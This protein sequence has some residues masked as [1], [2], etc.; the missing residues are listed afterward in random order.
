MTQPTPEQVATGVARLAE[1]AAT[2]PSPPRQRPWDFECDACHK[3]VPRVPLNPRSSF[4]VC[5]YCGHDNRLGNMPSD[6]SVHPAI[7]GLEQERAREGT[8]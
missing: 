8:P 1:I 3:L 7:R 5:D 4:W 6:R 2:A